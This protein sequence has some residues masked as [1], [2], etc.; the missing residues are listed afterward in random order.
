MGSGGSGSL[1][2]SSSPC[3]PGRNLGT[4][5]C[6]KQ[7]QT[8]HSPGSCAALVFQMVR[9]PWPQYSGLKSKTTS[10]CML[11]DLVCQDVVKVGDA[12]HG[13]L[14]PALVC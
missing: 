10:P 7:L 13:A 2:A 12:R 14:I 8:R 1:A 5:S 4:R 9:L 6:C 3:A 11:A